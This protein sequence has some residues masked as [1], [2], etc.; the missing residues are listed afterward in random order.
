MLAAGLPAPR[1][2]HHRS[3]V[4]YGPGGGLWRGR[5][6]DRGLLPIICRNA[7]TH[8]SRTWPGAGSLSRWRGFGGWSDDIPPRHSSL[9]PLPRHWACRRCSSR[10]RPIS[11]TRARALHRGRCRTAGFLIASPA[12]ACG[13][14]RPAGLLGPPVCVIGATAGPSTR[15]PSP[16]PSRRALAGQF[17]IVVAF[18]GGPEIDRRPLV[19]GRYRGPLRVGPGND[20]RNRVGGRYRHRRREWP[21]APATRSKGSIS[22]STR[23]RPLPAGGSWRLVF[24]PPSSIHT[25]IMARAPQTRR[26]SNVATMRA[27]FAAIG[28]IAPKVRGHGT[29]RETCPSRRTVVPDLVARIEGAAGSAPI[30]IRALAPDIG[31]VAG[32]ADGAGVNAELSL[33]AVPPPPWGGPIVPAL[34]ADDQAA[35]GVAI[36][37]SWG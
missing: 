14:H 26:P 24:S 21:S 31:R 13:H 28:R 29:R 22:R 37:C 11:F 5:A 35:D 18:A 33:A 25:P 19:A 9:Q 7:P 2:S 12:R 17:E 30:T 34:S 32:T 20:Q 4:G 23:D 27:A 3:T 6:G 8:R 16:P 15:I 10:D 1:G 36:A